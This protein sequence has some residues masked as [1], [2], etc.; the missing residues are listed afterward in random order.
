[1][2]D[3]Y[4][5]ALGSIALVVLALCYFFIIAPSNEARRDALSFS[6]TATWDDAHRAVLADPLR[7][8]ED[9]FREITLPPPP[10]NTAPQT[11]NDLNMLQEYEAHRTP[12]EI[13]DIVSEQSLD[14]AQFG[15]YVLAVYMDGK[16]FP[17]TA[18]LLKDSFHDVTVLT[19][20]EKKKYDRV[21]P[22]VLDPSLTPAI[23]VPGHPAYPAGHSVQT[24]FLAYVFGEIAPARRSEFI[25]R[26][27]Q[28]SKNRAIAGLHYPAD[29]AAG[30]L[31][32]EQFFA[33]MMQN[34]KFKTLLAAA[35]REWATH[36]ELV[37]APAT[38]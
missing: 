21:R 37:Q 9:L 32:A 18:L 19:L 15:T 13:R 10:K 38:P 4:V 11:Q 27:D 6:N 7:Y 25:A 3:K 8:P 33:I 28:I 31:L 24:H 22:S 17:A 5:P 23:A 12:E 30:V 26:A 16:K 34:E 29:N 1:M 20:R 35:K 36:P 2:F 14:T